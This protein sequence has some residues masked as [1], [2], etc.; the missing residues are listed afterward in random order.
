MSIIPQPL[1]IS[2]REGS[3]TL[4]K[5]TSIIAEIA[6]LAAYL[7]T[8]L[9]FDTGIIV[10]L[11]ATSSQIQLLLVE[12]QELSPEGYSISVN[13]TSITISAPKERGLF[14]GIQ[15]LRQ[16]IYEKNK[17]WCVDGVTIK[18]KPR[19]SWRGF[20]LDVG[21]HYHP[22]DTIK[23]LLDILALLKM[24]IFHW[25]LTQDQG[26][27][28]EIKK[29]P[30]L[31]E[32]G[33]K[34]KDTK[35]GSHLSKKFRGIPHEGFYTQDE[36]REIVQY[37]KERYIT[38]VPELNLPGHSTAAISSYPFLSC[39]EEQIEVKTRPGI[40]H[41][42]YCAGKESTFEFLE[43]VFNEVC[44]LFPS[45]IIHIGGDEAP[46]T[47]WKTCPHCQERIHAEDLKDEHE[48]QVYF[49]NRIASYLKSKGK[50]IIG[51][52]EI[53][54][55]TLE[56]MAIVQ[57][58]IGNP[59]KIGKFIPSGRRFIM[60]PFKHTYLDYNY[61]MFPM[62]NFY[63]EPV[64]TPIEKYESEILGVETPIWTEW[65]PNLE[66]LGWQVFPRLFAI[67]EV[68]WT[69]KTLIN[70][71]DYKKRI[72]RM[73]DF[74]DN[75]DMPYAPLD[76]VDPSNWKRYTHIRKWLQWPEL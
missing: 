47:R 9:S 44:E 27:R 10:N 59:K 31:T 55:D 70:Y 69:D 42:I 54:G 19:F 72:T 13:P 57:W 63:F 61:L 51:W 48:L 73:L 40:Y 29:Y 24:N 14:Y 22:V 39:T 58:W 17:N 64:P 7:R 46:K 30:K 45:D 74:L 36:I 66:R 50:R 43:N 23:K 71:S 4:S 21:R 5:E 35:I 1:Q 32:I 25:G 76:E 56:E 2:P 33:S 8:I 75:L 38:I 53:L 37:A 16:L 15:T 3:F 26:W 65:V 41:D 34:R 20:M 67:A 12:D 60:S 62:R 52:N 18:D 28:I 11:D 49:T 68:T 6:E